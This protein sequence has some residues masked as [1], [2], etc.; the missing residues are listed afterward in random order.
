MRPSMGAERQKMGCD[1]HIYIEVKTVNG[2]ELY[3]HPNVSRDYGLFTKMAGV[4]NYFE[5]EITPISEPRGLPEDA[6]FLVK[7]SFENWDID[8]HSASYLTSE[9]I[10]ELED[11]VKGRGKFPYNCLDHGVLHCYL[12]GNSFGGLK[13]Y[14]EEKPA[15]I[16]DVRF[17]FW[18]DN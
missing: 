8:A 4:R 15:W 11:F 12:E 13:K 5:G 17:V 7:K 10:I 6:S 14:P 2:W 9:E 18:F 3:S 16:E 1:I